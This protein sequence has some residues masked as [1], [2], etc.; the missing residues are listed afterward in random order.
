MGNAVCALRGAGSIWCT[1]CLGG[2]ETGGDGLILLPPALARPHPTHMK[3]PWLF[4]LGS[5]DTLCTLPLEPRSQGGRPLELWTDSGA[6]AAVAST[7]PLLATYLVGYSLSLTWALRLAAPCS[8]AGFAT[9]KQSASSS[10][11]RMLYVVM[12]QCRKE[13][14]WPRVCIP[15]KKLLDMMVCFSPSCAI[16]LH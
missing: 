9:M 8:V 4:P 10:G 14:D 1:R 15:A 16:R 7:V 11:M 13:T 5:L 3:C 12:A 2:T 6:G